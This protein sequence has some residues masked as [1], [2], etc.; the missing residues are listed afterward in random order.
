MTLAPRATVA[1]KQTAMDDPS[2]AA[3]FRADDCEI[4]SRKT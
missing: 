2:D 1:E 4:S 3:E